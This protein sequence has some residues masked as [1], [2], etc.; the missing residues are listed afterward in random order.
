METLLAQHK[1]F[2]AVPFAAVWVA[3]LLRNPNVSEVVLAL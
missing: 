2:V 1:Y 3:S